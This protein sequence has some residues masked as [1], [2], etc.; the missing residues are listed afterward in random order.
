[1]EIWSRVPEKIV[2]LQQHCWRYDRNF[3]PKSLCVQLRE[4][5]RPY[6]R[7]IWRLSLGVGQTMSDKEPDKD[8]ISRVRWNTEIIK[9]RPL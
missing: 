3:L 2:P 9:N 4:K 5:Q 6:K 1:M 7:G 8:R